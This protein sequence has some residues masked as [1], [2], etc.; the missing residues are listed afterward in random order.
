MKV[1]DT[2]KNVDIRPCCGSVTLE[3]ESGDVHTI[4]T[5]LILWKK[6]ETNHELKRKITDVF[7]KVFNLFRFFESKFFPSRPKSGG[8]RAIHFEDLSMEFILKIS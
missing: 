5:A 1:E 4:E 6:Q 2:Y 7:N 8:P 3:L